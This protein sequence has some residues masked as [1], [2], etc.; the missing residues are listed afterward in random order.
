M[1]NTDTEVDTEINR[2]NKRIQELNESR[3][4]MTSLKKRL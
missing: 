2:L 4:A 1:M 3:E